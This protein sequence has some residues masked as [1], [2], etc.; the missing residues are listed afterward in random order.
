VIASA[1]MVERG[2]KIVKRYGIFST[3]IRATTRP[4]INEIITNSPGY[5]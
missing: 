3:T 1:V 5:S 4:K 2:A